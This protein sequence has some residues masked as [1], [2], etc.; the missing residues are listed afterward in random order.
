MERMITQERVRRT[1]DPAAKLCASGID[2]H[3]VIAK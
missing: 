3:T 1:Q 2:P